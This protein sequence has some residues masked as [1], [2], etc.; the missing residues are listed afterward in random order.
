[1]KPVKLNIK[2]KFGSYQ[3]IIGSRIIRNLKTYLNKSSITFD[4]CLLVID[5]NVPRKM[6]MF[7]SR[8]QRKTFSE[9]KDL[10]LSSRS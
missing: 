2:T 3:I 8:C 4:K 5:K 10:E 1:M 9:S 6:K 7:E